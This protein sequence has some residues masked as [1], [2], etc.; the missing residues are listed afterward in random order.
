MK[1]DGA[2]NLQLTRFCKQHA[3]NVF[4]PSVTKIKAAMSELD[5]T[6]HNSVIVNKVMIKLTCTWMIMKSR[7]KIMIVIV[8][9]KMNNLLDMI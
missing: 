3:A 2:K 4:Q 9:R 5:S 6:V 7:I 1:T 8:A